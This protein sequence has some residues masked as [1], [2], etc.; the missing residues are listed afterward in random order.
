MA[1]DATTPTSSS[2]SSNHRPCCSEKTLAYLLL[3]FLLGLLLLLAGAEKFK[4]S[5]A[6]YS[7]AFANW[8]DT[9]DPANKDGEPLKWGRWQGIVKVIFESGGLN[10]YETFQFGTFLDGKTKEKKQAD[11]S[12]VKERDIKGGERISNFLG[13]VFRA[14]GLGLP[15]IMLF[16]GL[17]ILFGFLNRVALFIGGGVWL[18]LAAGQMILPDNPTVFVLSQYTLMVAVALA[19]VKYNRFAITR[20]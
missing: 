9:V 1:T 2:D 15:Y 7:Y 13:H 20:F 10:N 16:S 8:H 17:M 5:D 12:I 18:S 19:L 4:S 6:P 14:Y 11:G 3:R